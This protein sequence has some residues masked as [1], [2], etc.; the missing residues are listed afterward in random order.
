MTYFSDR[1]VELDKLA[2]TTLRCRSFFSAHGLTR[3]AGSKNRIKRVLCE[4]VFYVRDEQFLML[5][6]VMHAED[7]N[8]LDFIEQ[9]FV[10]I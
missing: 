9:T 5:L 4:D 6:F 10:G 3:P 1:L 8:R 7:E 2:R